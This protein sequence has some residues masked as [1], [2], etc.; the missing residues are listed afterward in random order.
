M[1]Q[2]ERFMCAALEEARAARDAG[3]TPV[4]AVVVRSG[5]VLSRGRNTRE[6]DA[7]ALGHAEINAI[8]NACAALGSW[9]LADCTLYVTL[10]PCAMCAGAILNARIGRVV[11]GARD[12]LA[13]CFGGVCDLSAMPLGDVRI[14]SGVLAEECAALLREFFASLRDGRP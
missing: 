10:E 8:R 14:K 1:T 7:S 2:D 9:R 5:V 6:R 3:E 13:G 4:G 11:Y 12:A